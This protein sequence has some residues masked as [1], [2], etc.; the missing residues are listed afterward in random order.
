M[1][2]DDATPETWKPVPSRAGYAVSDQGRVRGPRRVLKPWTNTNGYLYVGFGRGKHRTVHSLVVEAFIRPLAPGEET[3]HLNGNRQ[4]NRRVNLAIGS[5]A[6]NAADRMLHGTSGQRLTASL[7]REIR[8]RH[9]GGV[10]TYEFLA[11]EYGVSRTAIQLAIRGKT[12]AHIDGAREENAS[13]S[14]PVVKQWAR[15]TP[16]DVVAIR[17]RYSAGEKQRDIARDF[18]VSQMAVHQITSGKTW[19]HI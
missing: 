5:P 14:K 10:E 17:R 16:D 2:T 13:T 11:T 18:G 12:W 15:L 19:K 8:A 7:V 9:A 4:D 3:R 1:A 6:E